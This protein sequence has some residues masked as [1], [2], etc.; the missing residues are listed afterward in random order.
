MLQKDGEDGR[1]D[2]LRNEDVVK[3][4]VKKATN[5]L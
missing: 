4:K 3:E 1:T 5:V 2:S